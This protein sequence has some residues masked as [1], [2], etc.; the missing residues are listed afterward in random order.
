MVIEDDEM[1]HVLLNAVLTKLLGTEGVSVCHADRLSR[2]LVLLRQEH[3]DLILLDLM[4]PDSQGFDTFTVTKAEARHTPIVVLTGIDDE[5][6]GVR[7]VAQGAQDFFTK[8]RFRL[9]TLG[10]SIRYAIERHRQ[11]EE[12]KSVALVDELT[13]LY[14]RRGFVL[15]AWHELKVSTRTKHPV[16]LVFMDVNGLKIIN[17]T[18][19]HS[20]GD[21]ALREVAAV[22]SATFRES[23]LLARVGGDEFCALL[24][25]DLG[26]PET[27]ARLHASFRANASNGEPHAPTVSIG[28]ARYDADQPCSVEELM[29]RA[30]EAMYQDRRQARS[31][32]VVT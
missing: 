31:N 8:G 4:L 9:Q 3:F 15:L 13:G 26:G 7:A 29:E 23:D 14:N 2:A 18:R 20:C 30:D 17:D 5:E 28:V 24:V 6:L 19:G 16:T 22:L 10:R 11:F 27:L 12:L 32:D 21:A 1:Q 25:N